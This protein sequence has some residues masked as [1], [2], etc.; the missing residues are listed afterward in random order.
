MYR[1][2]EADLAYPLGWV[3]CGLPAFPGLCW[4]DPTVSGPIVG[5]GGW[6][7]Y[8][9]LTSHYSR[10]NR[11]RRILS[12]F[13][14]LRRASV[15]RPGWLSLSIR[16]ATCLSRSLWCWIFCRSTFMALR[17]SYSCRATS[18]AALSPNFLSCCSLYLCVSSSRC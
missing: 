8:A 4:F 18:S 3:P 11:P 6:E 16:D 9:R 14:L 15:C 5:Q 1:H 10:A 7:N 12:D 2:E 13:Q 17:R